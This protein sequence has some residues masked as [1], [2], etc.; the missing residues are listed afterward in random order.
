MEMPPDTLEDF[1]TK[2]SR[3]STPWCKSTSS[4]SFLIFPSHGK[5]IFFGSCLAECVFLAKN[6]FFSF[7][8]AKQLCMF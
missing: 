6:M 4:L 8:L 2:A 5:V 7:C 3:V 1:L